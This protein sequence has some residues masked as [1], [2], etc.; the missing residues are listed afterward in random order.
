MNEE[1]RKKTLN[2]AADILRYHQRSAAALYERLLEKGVVPEDAA[3]A[4]AKLQ[5]WGYLCDA[6]YAALVVRDLCARGYGKNHIRQ[7]LRQ[8]KVES[9]TAERAL[10]DF[11]P[12]DEKLQ[13][14]IRRKLK[15]E[16]TPDRRVLKKLTD[17]LFRRGFSWEEIRAALRKY[18]DS[19]DVGDL[20]DETD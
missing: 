17:G 19:E 12:N 8:K 14:Y 7:A 15:D 4:V 5:E 16:H 18:L 2:L 11:S 9:E 13:Q 3:Y 10:E 6:D 1:S 20:E